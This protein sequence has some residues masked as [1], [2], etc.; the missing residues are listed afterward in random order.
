MSGCQS[1]PSPTLE[2]SEKY[3]PTVSGLAADADTI[4]F[5]R[6]ASIGGRGVDDGGDPAARV[7]IPSVIYSVEIE[8]GTPA[9]AGSLNLLWPDSDKVRMA[10]Y[11]P[12]SIDGEYVFFLNKVPA[13]SRS[14]LKQFGTLYTSVAAAGVFTVSGGQAE[15][16]G[17][18]VKSLKPDGP[19]LR[20]NGDHAIAD[21][22]SLVGMTP[23]KA[24]PQG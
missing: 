8:E 9:K 11:A 14:G 15:S 16:L 23:G 13:S 6:I 2:S 3:Y 5:G 22:V 7:T 17:V 24:Q 12:L 21:V 19:A 18:S 1:A 20:R 10:D 4:V